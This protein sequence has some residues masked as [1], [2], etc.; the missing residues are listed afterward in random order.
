MSTQGSDKEGKRSSAQKADGTRHGNSPIPAISKV[1]GAH[2]DHKKTTRTM[3]DVM[4]D[5]VWENREENITDGNDS[6][7]TDK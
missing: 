2:G 5:Y 6:E 3:T 4:S 1:D 7:G